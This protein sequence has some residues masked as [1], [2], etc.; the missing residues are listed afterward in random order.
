MDPILPCRIWRTPS[1]QLCPAIFRHY[2]DILFKTI[3]TPLST[4]TPYSTNIYALYW[5]IL[6]RYLDENLQV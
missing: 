5:L 6:S 3:S 2:C 4:W 1:A